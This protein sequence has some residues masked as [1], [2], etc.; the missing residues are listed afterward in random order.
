MRR[1]DR[2]ITN[3]EALTILEHGEYGLLSTVSADNE[4]YGVPL[5]YCLLNG[6][7]YFHSA[8][9]GRK[10]DNIKNN[11]RVSF[12]VVG[13]TNPLPAQFATEYESCILQGTVTEVFG[14]EKQAAL[15]G[16]VSK[17]SRD[18]VSEGSQYI[19]KM[20]DRTRVFRISLDALSGKARK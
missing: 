20:R 13:R 12:C 8:V 5:N 19:E 7:I 15:E 10:I 18:F 4:P 9:E 2:Q 14:E 16:L 6:C 3:E 17:Y 11:Q 1:K